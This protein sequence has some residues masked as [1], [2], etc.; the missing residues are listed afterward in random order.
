MLEKFLILENEKKIKWKPLVFCDPYVECTS[1]SNKINDLFRDLYYVF[2][3]FKSRDVNTFNK[4]P[5]IK[6]HSK[7]G[8]EFNER[9]AHESKN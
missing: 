7:Y 3:L 5:F 6:V 2:Y 9:V 8:S 4:F 1:I